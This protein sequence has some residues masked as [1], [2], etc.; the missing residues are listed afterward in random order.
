MFRRVYIYIF[1]YQYLDL[2]LYLYLYLYPLLYVYLCLYH[3][4]LFLCLCL[5]LSIYVCVSHIAGKG[6][7]GSPP[8]NQVADETGFTMSEAR[9]SFASE[10]YAFDWQTS[11]LY[12]QKCFF[13]WP[14][15]V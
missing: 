1:I 10:K 2:Y 9:P 14:A 5:C 11:L 3:L 6:P 8:E 12:R 13:F 15:T 4:Y 7:V